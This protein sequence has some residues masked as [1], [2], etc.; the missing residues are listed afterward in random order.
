MENAMNVVY[1]KVGQVVCRRVAGEAVLVPVRGRLADMQRLFALD[2]VG[3]VVWQRIDGVTPLA[4]VRDAVLEEFEVGREQAEA[5]IAAFAG[6]LAAAGLVE[7]A[8]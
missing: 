1:R 8:E 7:Q 2:P 5:D 6:D 4:G 3:E